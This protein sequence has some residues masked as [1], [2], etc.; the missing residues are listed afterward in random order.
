MK[1]IYTIAVFCIL[2]GQI[3]AQVNTDELNRLLDSG[4]NSLSSGN[5]KEAIMTFD[6]A[7]RA[8]KTKNFKEGS[9]DVYMRI[10]DICLN[11][12]QSNCNICLAH[13]YYTRSRDLDPKNEMIWK[14]LDDER[15][16]SMKTQ[17]DYCNQCD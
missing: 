5:R 8:S 16:K 4:K 14:K 2:V 10:G 9:P 15:F 17:D 12:P 6:K 13:S 7:I 1:R 3:K 11:I